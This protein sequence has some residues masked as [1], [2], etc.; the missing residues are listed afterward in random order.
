MLVTCYVRLKMS[1]DLLIPRHRFDRKS[2]WLIANPTV[3]MEIEV[4]VLH[5]DQA[6]IESEITLSNPA[7][8]PKAWKSEVGTIACLASELCTRMRL[9]TCELA[10]LRNLTTFF[11]PCIPLHL[12]PLSLWGVWPRH[13]SLFCLYSTSSASAPIPNAR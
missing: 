6:S 11:C 3:V 4:L 1:T 12:I 2:R 13:S 8:A 7:L 10:L 5:W 9:P